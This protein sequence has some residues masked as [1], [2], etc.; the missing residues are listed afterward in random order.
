MEKR[1]RYVKAATVILLLTMAMLMISTVKVKAE[2]VPTIED[3]TPD[4]NETSEYMIGNCSVS[5]IFLESNSTIP[6]YDNSTENWN[7]TRIDKVLSEI[8]NATDWWSSRNPNANFTFYI[9]N[10][11][12]QTGYEP[13][14]HNSGNE[15]NSWISDVMTSLG[16]PSGG[17]SINQMND[18][19]NA[20]R[21]EHN[22]DWSFM[23]LVVDSL[24]NP[25]GTFTDGYYAFSVTGG[26]YIVMTYDNGNN[27]IENMDLVCAHEIGHIFWALDEHG[28][29]PNPIDGYSG[30]L[31]V[32]IA[33]NGGGIMDYPKN[34]NLSGGPQEVNGTWGQ[35]GWRDNDNDTILDIVDTSQIVNITHSEIAENKL[36]YT[37]NATVTPYCP[38][39]NPPG[40]RRNV[41]INKIQSVQ[42]LIDNG[43]WST[44]AMIPTT[45]E[46]QIFY[47]GTKVNV[48][49]YAI[50]N[51]TFQVDLTTLSPGIHTINISATNQWN[52]SGYATSTFY[53][54]TVIAVTNIV[55]NNTNI[56]VTIKNNGL[57]NITTNVSVAWQHTDPTLPVTLNPGES[58]TLNFVNWTTNPAG[59]YEIT[60]VT[61]VVLINSSVYIGFN[62]TTVSFGV[63]GS[64]ASQSDSTSNWI[65]LAFC[66]L[67]ASFIAPEFSKKKKPDDD[68]LTTTP[69]HTDST[70]NMWQNLARHQLT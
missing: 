10:R 23:I 15:M 48:T 27:G 9:E 34:W 50:V 42:Y 60:A 6:P 40:N 29:P 44:A 17:T 12:V 47:N 58:K 37:G 35:V 39:G 57:S 28:F 64:Q 2:S 68:L 41:T 52:I 30:Y 4:Y 18:Y 3:P 19:I 31:N 56:N 5:I 14:N 61:D 21:N 11:T 38:N 32:S 70:E 55:A 7:Q 66:M 25:N 67:S 13:I 69:E 36:K 65:V 1:K 49:T 51:F 22:T 54:N 43:N 53:L 26:P 59:H 24:N 16:Y 45:L 33:S 62:K 20:F 46:K 63:G 8:R